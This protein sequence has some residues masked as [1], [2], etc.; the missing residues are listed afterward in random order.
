MRAEQ[1]KVTDVDKI[2]YILLDTIVV[3][4]VLVTALN[5]HIGYDKAAQIAKARTA[6]AALMKQYSWNSRVEVLDQGVVKDLRIELVNYGPM[7]QLQRNVLNDQSAPLPFGFLRRRI[8]ENER[9][10]VE[11]Y[12]VGLRSLL[13]QYTLTADAAFLNSHYVVM[14]EDRGYWCLPEVDLGLPLSPAMYGVVA[15]RVR[16][17]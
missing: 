2:F 11:E 5:P 10:K 7:G 9:A 16:N 4:S 1:N 3:R 15:S 8:A 13:E 14:R 12:L 6:N 17:A